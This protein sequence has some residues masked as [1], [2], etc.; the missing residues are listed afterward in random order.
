MAEM[1]VKMVSADS[2]AVLSDCDMATQGYCDDYIRLEFWTACW[3]C[4]DLMVWVSNT[5]TLGSVTWTPCK[6]VLSTQ[7]SLTA[8]FVWT[9][10]CNSCQLLYC[11]TLLLT[12]EHSHRP[13]L[14]SPLCVGFSV[15]RQ[16][17]ECERVKYIFTSSSS[18][19]LPVHAPF[20]C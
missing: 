15:L 5:C 6:R 11:S 13:G 9:A 3:L 10:V 4:G 20:F 12:L 19:P 2:F 7:W 18:S 8:A 14:P 17:N 1:G 16:E